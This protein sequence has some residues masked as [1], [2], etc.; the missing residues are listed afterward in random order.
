[1]LRVPKR[2]HYPRWP[3]GSPHLGQEE[4]SYMG[5][6]AR[7]SDSCPWLEHTEPVCSLELPRDEPRSGRRPVGQPPGG[8]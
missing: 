4:G 3:G 6:W 7:S 5:C 8:F 1:M 2:Q